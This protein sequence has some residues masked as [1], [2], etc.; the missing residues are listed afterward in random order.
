MAVTMMSE[1]AGGP[2]LYNLGGGLIRRSW[3]ASAAA[4]RDITIAVVGF[5]IGLV[6]FLYGHLYAPA[7]IYVTTAIVVGVLHSRDRIREEIGERGPGIMQDTA[8]ALAGL[9]SYDGSEPLWLLRRT[10]WAAYS[11]RD[12]VGELAVQLQDLPGRWPWSTR[13]SAVAVVELAGTELGAAEWAAE[14]RRAA[15]FGAM[16][17]LAAQSTL[18]VQQVDFVTSIRPAELSAQLDWD[19]AHVAGPENQSEAAELCALVAPWCVERHSWMV[20]RVDGSRLLAADWADS[21]CEAAWNAADTLVRQAIPAQL[22]PVRALGPG[23]MGGLLRHIMV[24]DWSPDVWESAWSTP[25]DAIPPFEAHSGNVAVLDPS[26]SPVW[27]HAAGVVEADGWP[28]GTVKPDLLDALV[29]RI[30][31]APWR[32]VVVQ[33]ATMSRRSAQ[34]QAVVSGNIAASA[35]RAAVAAGG[36]S[37]GEE[38]ERVFA[39]HGLLGDLRRNAAG[40]QLVLRV[41]VSHRT[42][43]ELEDA[44]RA[45][46]DVLDQ[47]GFSGQYWAGRAGTLALMSCLPTASGVKS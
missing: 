38:Q 9:G 22:S 17:A 39:A 13:T 2:R 18:R 43:E 36:L 21:A 20:V 46:R 40:I 3:M 35:H 27:W 41:L 42:E 34:A 6:A 32:L 12:G 26:G 44:K 23:R 47:A 30:P 8:A 16:L 15:A 45:V 14:N 37:T 11:P 5:L 29:G 1:E 31:A 28:D 4:P 25:A 10:R 24:P 19:A 7:P 33:C